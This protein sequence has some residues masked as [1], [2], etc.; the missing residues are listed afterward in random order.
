[1][2]RSDFL[3]LAQS[4]PGEVVGTHLRGT[5]DFRSVRYREPQLVVMGGEGPGL[6]DELAAAC[7][8]LVKSPMSGNLDSLNLAVATGLMLYQVRG[9][10]LKL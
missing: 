2:G 8:K 1:M 9:P 7:S 4:W 10:Y 6:T 5:D 3:T